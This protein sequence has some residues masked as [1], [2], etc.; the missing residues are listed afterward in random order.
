M[1]TTARPQQRYDH[2]LRTHPT[3]TGDVTVATDLESLAGRR[4]GGSAEAPLR[5]EV[6]WHSI[7]AR[8]RHEFGT[9]GLETAQLRKPEG[10][11]AQSCERLETNLNY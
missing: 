9:P 5:D 3:H 7:V 8:K 2:Q 4:V 1:P 6:D 11:N 10:Q